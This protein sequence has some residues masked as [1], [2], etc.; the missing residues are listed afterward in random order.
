MLRR[1]QLDGV[2]V[3]GSGYR[4]GH[5]PLANAT[6]RLQPAMRHPVLDGLEDGFEITDEIYLKSA[7][8]ERRVVPLLRGQYDFV[9]ANFTAPPLAPPAEQAAWKHPPGSHLI[10]W[11]NAANASPVVV[12]DVGDGPRAF[13]NPAFRRLLHNALVWTA[14]SE[15]RAWAKSRK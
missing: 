9:A 13:A 2:D 6:I 10:V 15:A 7:D 3:P 14:S 1:G 11:A 5:G 4:G 12:S 8:F